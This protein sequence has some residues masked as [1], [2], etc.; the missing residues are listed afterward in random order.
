MVRRRVPRRRG[1]G[2]IPPKPRFFDVRT[3][4]YTVFDDVQQTAWECVRGM[5]HSFGYNRASVESDFLAQGELLWSLVDITA[6]GGNL[7]L[8]VGPRGED[9]SIPDAQ[10]QRLE[11]LSAFTQRHGGAL[12]GTR[13]WTHAAEGAPGAAEVRYTSRGDQ[14]Y[15]FVRG[16]EAAPTDI[17]LTNV[18]ASSSTRVTDADGAPLPHRMTERGLTVT[19]TAP[20]SP[21]VPTSITLDGVVAR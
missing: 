7:L 16:P 5:D 1:R 9:A 13:P 11:W 10:L 6:K 17:L 15:A 21:D 20:L 4:E 3:P 19:L 12:F 18:G 14:V 8:N 2:V